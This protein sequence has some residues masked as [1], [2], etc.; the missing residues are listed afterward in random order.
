MELYKEL[1]FERLA[2]KPSKSAVESV[3][4]ILLILNLKINYSIFSFNFRIS[5]DLIVQDDSSNFSST[6]NADFET[7]ETL[8]NFRCRHCPYNT[9]QILRLQ[10]HENKHVLKAEQHVLKLFLQFNFYFII[11]IKIFFHFSVNIARIHVVPYTYCCNIRASMKNPLHLPRSHLQMSFLHHRKLIIS[12]QHLTFLM[13]MCNK[14]VHLQFLLKE[15]IF[16]D[17]KLI[18]VHIVHINRNIIAI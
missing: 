14:I 13:K 9:D 16:A 10:K 5:A 12:K 18:F 8:K 6:Y 1:L 4:K 2:W 3:N 11:S 17:V 15:D 7:K